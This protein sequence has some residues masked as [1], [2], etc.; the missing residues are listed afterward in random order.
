MRKLLR[1]F[2]AVTT[3][4]FLSVIS[5]QSSAQVALGIEAGYVNS[6]LIDKSHNPYIS[7]SGINNFLV[8]AKMEANLSKSIIFQSGLD[9]IGKG[10]FRGTTE[11][12]LSGTTSTTKLNY[13]QIPLNLKY[14]FRTKNGIKPFLGAGF[15]LAAGFSGT[16]KGYYQ[17]T[18]GSTTPIDER[19]VFTNNSS[20]T[21]TTVKPIDAGYNV[22]GG[23]AF[24]HWQLQATYSKGFSKVFTS[25]STNMV[26][27]VF[28]VTVA[29]M[30]SL[31][32]SLKKK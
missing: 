25:G 26:H 27:S 7:V 31:K 5:I 1:L 16:E 15:Y 12:A 17:S 21:E 8:G 23:V 14:S 32:K 11:F 29:Y 24:K 4:V 20:A 30:F 2:V 19:V 13:L 6:G 18:S 3:V 9:Y 22:F 10:G 28:G